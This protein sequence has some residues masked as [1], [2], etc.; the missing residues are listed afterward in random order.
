MFWCVG[1]TGDIMLFIQIHCWDNMTYQLSNQY[2]F[3]TSVLFP[4]EL[5]KVTSYLS[6]ILLSRVVLC[7]MC[8]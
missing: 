1:I 7:Y 5:A 6:I 2:F 4:T 3:T 8:D